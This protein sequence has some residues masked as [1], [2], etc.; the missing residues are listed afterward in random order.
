MIIGTLHTNRK[1][2]APAD[3]SVGDG[4]RIVNLN[5]NWVN[6][7]PLGR[8]SLSGRARVGLGLDDLMPSWQLCGRIGACPTST[9]P[10]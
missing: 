3:T 4:L 10:S 1:G 2:V 8:L 6:V 9:A 5:E 7:E